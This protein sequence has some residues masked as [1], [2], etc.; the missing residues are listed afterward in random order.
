MKLLLTGAFKY[1]GEQL[2]II[3]TLGYDIVFIQ[4]ERIRL[5]ADVA[6]IEAVVC[7]SLFLYNDIAGFK[8]LKYIQLTSAG[9]DRAPV[10]FI[11]KHGI[12][13]FNAAGVYSI[14][15]AEWAVLKILEIYKKSQLFYEMQKERKWV[16]Q[17]G[18]FELAGKTAVIIG[19]GSV[20]Q[21]TAKRLK[22]FGVKI[23]GVEPRML[24]AG[25]ACLADGVCMPSEI[26]TVL[27]SG[28]IVILTLPLSEHTAHL[29]NSCRFEA[30]KQDS[31]LINVSR[32]GVIDETALRDNLQKGKFLG[33]ALDV[34]EEEP[35]PENSDLWDYERLI[36]TPHN[37]FVSDKINERLF[38]L[39]EKNLAKF[40]SSG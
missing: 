38:E 10:E 14:P 37:S 6:G 18:I 32:G 25:E 40:I 29:M 33:A 9:L 8:N 3:K 24:E 4:D 26:D 5:E 34:F 17:S 31:V 27:G 13:L 22:A 30:M 35:I 11:K 12:K 2:K 16:K 23:I 19:F 28:D 15:M 21:E 20:G 7:N 39:I 36:I 1:T